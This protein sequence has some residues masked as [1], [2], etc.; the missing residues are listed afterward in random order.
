MHTLLMLL[1][2]AFQKPEFEVASIKPAAPDARGMYIRTTPGGTLTITNMSLKEIMVLA[3]RVQPYQIEG[4]PAWI[5]SAHF[6][7]SAKPEN[8]PKDGDLPLMLQALL[9]DRFQLKI[10]HQTKDLP[11]YALVLA[12]KDGKLGPKL[13]ESQ[14]GGCTK[15]DP[16]NPPPPRE[17]GKAPPRNCGQQ[18]MSPRSLTAFQVPL[19]NICP[20]LGRILGRT[21]VDKT[22]LKGNYDIS[23]EWAP[24]DAQQATLPPDAPRPDTDASASSIFTAIQEQLGLKLESQKGPVEMLVVQKAEKP[25]GN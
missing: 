9:A 8:K 2:L 6:D 4:G 25:S 12:R 11:I 16:N 5:S 13:T 24:D 15:P 20:M 17:T 7:I 18:M 14:E 1:A 21:V 10:E 22:G 3:W 19:E 23:M